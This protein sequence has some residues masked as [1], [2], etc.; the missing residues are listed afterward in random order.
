MVKKNIGMFI[1]LGVFYIFIETM[2]TAITSLK[3][4]LVGQS[5]VYMFIVGGFLGWTL[6]LFNTNT[7]IRT[8]VPVLFQSIIGG[9]WIIL[10]EF[11]S[12]FILNVVLKFNL[13]DYSTL[14][15]NV[16]GQVSLLFYIF[17]VLLC[18]FA[19]WADDFFRFHIYNEGLKVYSLLDWYKAFFGSQETNVHLAN[20]FIYA[21]NFALRK[22]AC[23]K[24]GL[25][26]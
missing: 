21:S 12:G 18:P 3:W 14:P 25:V 2:F 1:L 22:R 5:S 19:F 15:F 7:L 8:K 26:C 16:M 17:W 13:W 6:G 23:K 11:L 9:L 10:I 24:S 4:R 20:T